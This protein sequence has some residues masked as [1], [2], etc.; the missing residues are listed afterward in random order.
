MSHAE[1]LER[2]T[3]QTR[4]QLASTLDELRACM[5]P[6]HVLDQLSDRVGDGAAAAMMRNLKEQ[7][8][9]NPLPLALMGA[10]LA[11]LMLGSRPR[12]GGNV[13]RGTDRLRDAADRAADNVRDAADGVRDTATDKGSEWRDKASM[14]TDRARRSLDEAGES[15]RQTADST[16]DSAR[17]TA[18]SSAEAIREAASTTAESMQRAASAGYEAAADTA[19]RTASSISESTKAAR[20]QTLRSGNT[21]LEFC[22]EQPLLVA[23]LGIAVGALVGAL[24]PATETEDRLMG[25]TSDDLKKDAQEVASEQYEG[26]RKVADRAVEAGQDEAARQAHAKGSQSGTDAT[27]ASDAP[28]LVPSAP[29]SSDSGSNAPV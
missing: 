20:E 3:E 27:G 5:T 2:E 6:G 19:R 13:T 7:A 24:L 25:A 14:T 28:T 10:S 1:Q 22:R 23:G 18:A 11:W 26:A 4:A 15:L 9:S 21:L 12:G 16:A 29:H 17:Q 8:V